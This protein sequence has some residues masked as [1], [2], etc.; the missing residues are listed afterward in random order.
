MRSLVTGAARLPGRRHRQALPQ[1]G[2]RGRVMLAVSSGAVMLALG[3]AGCTS[4]TCGGGPVTWVKVKGGTAVFAE[5]LSAAPDYIFPFAS[6]PYTSVSNQ[7]DFSYLMYRPLYWFGNGAAPL[8]NPS[9]SL[10]NTPTWAGNTATITLRH[11]R[12]SDGTPV[13]TTDVMFWVNMLE[14]VGAADWGAYTGFPS[15]FVSSIEVVSPTELQMTTNKAYSHAWFLYNELSQITPMPPAWDKTAS[16]PGDCAVRV[17]ACQA[18]HA[19]LNAHAK[20][21]RSYV[22]SPL[23]RVVDGPWKLSAFNAGGPVTF[24]PNPHYSGPVKPAL[25]E[26]E[27][28][29][30]T[31]AA[32]E[33]TALLQGL[34]EI[35]V[36]Y[37]PPTEGALPVPRYDPDPWHAY[38]HDYLARQLPAIWTL[39]G[40]YQLT[41]VAINL[42]GVSPQSPTLTIN[43]ENWY[44]VSY[45]SSSS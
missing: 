2:L 30:F 44:W 27:E 32:A 25:A 7:E 6:R 42:K 13:T 31:T 14:A 20:R 29:P 26:F 34:P 21:L 22:S 41:L 24:V 17:S 19:Y 9:L 40:T 23:W 37:L 36:G 35:G 10:A 12:W 1:S 15:S 4:S 33:Y 45:G 43:P 3:A 11:Y 16:G 5:P 38:Y 39:S 8:L 28:V 18:V